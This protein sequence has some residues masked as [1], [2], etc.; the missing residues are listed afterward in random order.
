MPELP[1]VEVTRR[2]IEPRLVGRTI[3]EV[4]TTA[5]SYFFL[6]PPRELKR[7]LVGRRVMGLSR[8]GKYLLLDLDDGS[9]VLLHLG[10]TGQLFTASAR[11]V[12]LL[13]ATGQSALSPER[14][15][16]FTPDAHTHLVLR[17]A[18]DGE[19]VLFRDVRKFGKV[20]WLPEEAS[21]PRLLKLGPD[22]LTTTGARLFEAT[23]KRKASIK[24]VLLD[25][26]VIAG[27]GNI[28]ADE[29]L[30][31]AG[32]RPGRAARS[33]TRAECERL[34]AAI[35]AVLTRSIET[36]GSSI[37]DYVQPDGSDGAYQDERRVYARTNE[38]CFTCGTA[39]K[40]IVLGQR[41]THYC[42]TCQ[43]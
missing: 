12:R 22:A 16:A 6:T 35:R 5:P 21:D 30:F 31:R 25:Q 32:I 29:A 3:R 26:E 4:V 28:Y 9:R 17:F 15:E 11:S 20:R 37:S 8:H 42:P 10:M 13:R 18:D 24:T 33:L 39:I 36:G 43:R 38:P 40:R 1:E 41:S 23:R 7:R 27:V 34:S 19:D 2:R 14:Q